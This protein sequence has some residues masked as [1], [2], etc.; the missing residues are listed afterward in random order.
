MLNASHKCFTLFFTPFSFFVKKLL[1]FDVVPFL[2]LNTSAMGILAFAAPKEVSD[3]ALEM[4]WGLLGA[5]SC[6]SAQQQVL[7]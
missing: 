6:M 5:A 7:P 2:K 4:S 1:T 3:L